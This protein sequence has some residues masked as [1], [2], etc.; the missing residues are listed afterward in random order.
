MRSIRSIPM[1]AYLLIFYNVFLLHGTAQAYL[2]I[3]AQSVLV[4]PLRQVTVTANLGDVLIMV[5]AGA[6][7]VELFK[8]ARSPRVSV[9]EHLLSIL[10]CVVFL[11]EFLLVAVAG[12]VPFLTLTLMSFLD[13]MAGFMIS[14]SSARRN[15]FRG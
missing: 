10:V 7:Y 9:K 13:V 6:L 11:A 5:G 2:G 3:L 1:F 12:T 14:V 4:I 15:F 8:K